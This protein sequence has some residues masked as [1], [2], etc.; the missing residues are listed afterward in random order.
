MTKA[1]AVVTIIRDARTERS[2]K[3]SL[4]R[5]RAAL[6]VLGLS[7]EDQV[8]VEYRLCYRDP[9]NNGEL[10]PKFTEGSGK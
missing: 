1:E 9:Y 3:A 8:T 4:K 6:S 7:A 5:L 2:S 10:Y